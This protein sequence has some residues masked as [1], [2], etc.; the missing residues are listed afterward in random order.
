MKS[1][2]IPFDSYAAQHAVT[3]RT[4]FSNLSLNPAY[5]NNDSKINQE[6]DS[7]QKNSNHF[8]PQI[9]TFSINSVDEEDIPEEKMHSPRTPYGSVPDPVNNSLPRAVSN[10]R[11]Q[12]RSYLYPPPPHTSTPSMETMQRTISASSVDSNTSYS[13]LSINTTMDHV[14]EHVL[15]HYA[16]TLSATSSIN[17]SGIYSTSTTPDATPVASPCGT[18]KAYKLKITNLDRSSSGDSMTGKEQDRAEPA[19]ADEKQHEEKMFGAKRDLTPEEEARL[20]DIRHIYYLQAKGKKGAF[21]LYKQGAGTYSGANTNGTATPIL[22]RTSSCNS[23]RDGG[24]ECSFVEDISLEGEDSLAQRGK[25]AVVES[26]LDD[27]METPVPTTS[28]IQMQMEDGQASPFDVD[29]DGQ[30]DQ[31][32]TSFGF[33][34]AVGNLPEIFEDQEHETHAITPHTNLTPGKD[35]SD[36]NENSVER[37]CSHFDIILTDDE[38]E[39]D[40]DDDV[41][42]IPSSHDRDSV[43]IAHHRVSAKQAA[44]SA[45]RARPIPLAENGQIKSVNDGND[46]LDD[47]NMM[48]LEDEIASKG[49]RFQSSRVLFLDVDG[50]LLS[51]AEQAKLGKGEGIKFSDE[52]TSLMS[53]LCRETDCD[54]VVSSTWQFYHDTH[55][56]YLVSYL[57]ACGWRRE[58]VHTLLDLLPQHANDGINYGREWY[59][60]SPYCACRARGIQKIVSL[61]APYISSWCCLD[62]LPLHSQKLVCIPKKEDLTQVVD[63]LSEA[64]FQPIT[65]RHAQRDTLMPDI[66]YCVKYAM[67]TLPNCVFGSQSYRFGYE[68]DQTMIYYQADAIAKLCKLTY[69]IKDSRLYQQVIQNMMAVISQYVSRNVQYQGI[70]AIAPFLIQTDQQIG[71]T[72]Q[73]I[74]NAITLLTYATVP[75][76]RVHATSNSL[77][78]PHL[79]DANQNIVTTV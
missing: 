40:D 24:S 60:Q 39:E 38:E 3:T 72:P 76:L 79:N 13:N 63:A 43:A 73:N 53:K 44:I 35:S 17:R 18:P 23:L 47:E 41:E 66:K 8:Q 48:D 68:F 77:P 59:E 28:A 45:L 33:F 22:S 64:Y 70:P 26:D 52:I 27:E 16:P 12:P 42:P 4:S 30:P 34:G 36:S 50:V 1:Y 32:S 6:L 5:L 46:D 71:I 9:T 29:E 57:E 11:N 31:A 51:V 62:D 2:R 14:H 10:N 7:S 61:Y 65:W 25:A 78:Q 56:K 49:S 55:L 20:Q 74:E 75:A 58:K 19:Q 67:T 37:D 69:E 21:Q 54:I 15:Q